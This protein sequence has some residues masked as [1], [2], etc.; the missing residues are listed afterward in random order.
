MVCILACMPVRQPLSFPVVLVASAAA[1]V[2]A[3]A[4]ACGA[5][6]RS[7][8]TEPP[9]TERPAAA[10]PPETSSGAM[11]PAS[12]A[13]A[14]AAEAGLTALVPAA[15]SCAA[16]TSACAA[17][18]T[19]SGLYASYRKDAFLPEASYAELGPLPTTGGRMQIAGIATASGEIATVR[20]DG[21]TTDEL[22]AKKAIDW[23]HVWPPV[24]V[25]GQPIWLAFHS[26]SAKWDTAASTTLSIES[27][28][29]VLASGTALVAKAAVAITYVTT[30]DG[31]KT[32]LV[33][34]ANVDAVPHTVDRL[35]IDGKD[36]TTS[37]CIPKKTLAPGERALWSVPRCTPEAAGS[38]WTVA[39]T[40]TDGPSAAAVGRSV[41]VITPR[42]AGACRPIS[43]TPATGCGYPAS[44]LPQ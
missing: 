17:L 28:T 1:V 36:V 32:M 22:L 6:E 7:T 10:P 11:P 37:A 3:F 42:A 40:L 26:R 12:D 20:I 31:G 21:E 9:D 41:G 15:I 2:A 13:A 44:R 35:V 8:A 16:G 39:L 34:A 25:A 19:L 38:P 30:A 29:A 24:T 4:A 33:H 14:D 43:A 18:A 5:N 23:Y 27:T